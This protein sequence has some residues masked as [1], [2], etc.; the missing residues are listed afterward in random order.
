M[1]QSSESERGK[2]MQAVRA[3]YENGML[4]LLDPVQLREGEQVEV[5]VQMLEDSAHESHRAKLRAALADMDIQ[6]STP[7]I[8]VDDELGNVDEEA[9]LSQIQEELSGSKPLS[10]III[11]DRREI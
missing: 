6:W 2:A 10:E 1:L 3:I 9:L 7:D 5:V 8:S 4:R 11:E